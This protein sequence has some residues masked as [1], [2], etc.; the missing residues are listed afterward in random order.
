MG[1]T[2]A[3]IFTIGFTDTTAE[4]FFNRLQQSGVRKVIDTRLWAETQLSGFA[5]KKDLPFF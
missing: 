2:K 5:K 1:G 3:K 4:D